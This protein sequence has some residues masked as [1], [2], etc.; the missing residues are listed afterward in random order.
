ME[1]NTARV[2]DLVE[3]L[4]GILV[5]VEEE[6]TLLIEVIGPANLDAAVSALKND[7]LRN[8]HET[9]LQLDA[10]IKGLRSHRCG[11]H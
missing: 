1:L 6:A 7:V 8:V 9:N 2:G 3:R 11:P 5:T 4:D 10:A